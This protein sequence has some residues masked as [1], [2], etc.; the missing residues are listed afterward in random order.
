MRKVGKKTID[1]LR[2]N[3][4]IVYENREG[5]MGEAYGDVKD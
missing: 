2:N 3:M 1:N 4:S 5:I